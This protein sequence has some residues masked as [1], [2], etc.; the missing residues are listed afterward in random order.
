MAERMA[1]LVYSGPAKCLIFNGR[2]FAQFTSKR[3]ILFFFHQTTNLGVGSSNLPRRAISVPK[4]ARRVPPFVRRLRSAFLNEWCVI[5]MSG[6]NGLI[7]RMR[8]I[9]FVPNGCELSRTRLCASIS[10]PVK[11][12][13]LAYCYLPRIP[14]EA[15]CILVNRTPR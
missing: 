4:W 10:H 3:L 7:I 14:P 2:R 13:P 12:V 1:D 9:S 11:L 15:V 6:F 5:R 8:F